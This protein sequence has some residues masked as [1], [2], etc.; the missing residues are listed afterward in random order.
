MA[1]LNGSSKKKP[2]TKK[3]LRKFEENAITIRQQAGVGLYE[4]FD[5]FKW[6]KELQ[7]EVQYADKIE[8]LS[9]EQLDFLKNISPKEWSGG[10][11]KDK[12]PN[13]KMLIILHPRQ[14]V[15]RARITIFEEI[16]HDFYGHQPSLVNGRRCYDDEQEQ[17]A[18]WTAA[19]VL[20]PMK[21]VAEGVF[22]RKTARDIADEFGSSVELA[23]MRIKT[24]QL[25][26]LYQDNIL[27]NME[28]SS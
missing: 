15:E 9:A 3:L 20:L 7:I 4:S 11:I 14:T 5:P 1:R 13:G 18:Y 8:G 24:L 19:A 17:E 25:W 10:G 21:I 16:A 28:V 2:P 6:L 27:T 12:L 23:E 26:K 22:L